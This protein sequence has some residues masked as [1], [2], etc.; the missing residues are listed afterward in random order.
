MKIKVIGERN[1]GTNFIYKAK[2]ENIECELIDPIDGIGGH[3]HFF[4]FKTI[5]EL[6]KDTIV[7]SVVRNYMDWVNSM[8]LRPWNLQYKLYDSNIIDPKDPNFFN[9]EFYSVN[10]DSGFPTKYDTDIIHDDL[11]IY[12]DRKYKNIVEARN[13]KINFMIKDIPRLVDKSIIVRYE[14]FKDNY[15][16][17]ML[18]LLNTLQLNL[19]SDNI[20]EI[21]SFKG[22]GGSNWQDYKIKTKIWSNQQILDFSKDL[23]LAQESYLGYSY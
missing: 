22:L 12:E 4:N 13:T 15:N 7:I 5:S 14:D 19:I 1:S 18:T 16:G 3:K 17:S 21:N 10:V 2:E 20:K 23:N 11:H 9:E 8:R 6:E